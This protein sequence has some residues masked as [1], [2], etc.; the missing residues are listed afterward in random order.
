MPRKSTATKNPGTCKTAAKPRSIPAAPMNEWF[1]KIVSEGTGKRF[2]TEHNRTWLDVT[3]PRFE[4]FF[5]A[6]YFLEMVCKCARELD[7]LAQR[8]PSSWASVLYL[9][10]L[11]R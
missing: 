8:L 7:D 11:H 4:A 1:T 9:H 2:A 6:Q 5:D 3:R 10:G